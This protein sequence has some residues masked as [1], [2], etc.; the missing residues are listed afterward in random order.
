MGP[1]TAEQ[2]VKT[3]G[4]DA[5]DDKVMKL[6]IVPKGMAPGRAEDKGVFNSV[7]ELEAPFLFDLRINRP[8]QCSN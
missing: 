5:C 2:A 7:K 4:N 1:S 8:P 6:Y 3:T